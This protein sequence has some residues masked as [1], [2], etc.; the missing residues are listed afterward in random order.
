VGLD[1]AALFNVTAQGGLRRDTKTQS[2][3]VPFHLWVKVEGKISPAASSNNIPTQSIDVPEAQEIQHETVTFHENREPV[4]KEVVQFTEI[5]MRLLKPA[6]ST[7]STDV[8]RILSRPVIVNEFDW[9]TSHTANQI[10]YVTNVPVNWLHSS[11]TEQVALWENKVDGFALLRCKIVLRVQINAMRF[12][13]GRLLVCF[14]PQ[15]DLNT[16]RYEQTNE[17]LTLATQLP[18]V[19]IDCSV[20]STAIL[21]IPYVS[22]TLGY[23]IATGKYGHGYVD[24]RVYSPLVDPSG[25]GKVG[26]TVWAHLEDVELYYPAYT[27]SGRK[28]KRTTARGGSSTGT[29]HE[30]ELKDATGGSVSSFMSGV[31]DVAKKTKEV[32]LLSS[33]AAPVEWAANIGSSIASAFGWSNPSTSAAT[34]QVVVRMAAAGHNIDGID[35]SQKLGLKQDNSVQCLPGAF[36]TNVDEMA[37]E[38]IASHPA[39]VASSTWRSTMVA[40]DTVATYTLSPEL[41]RTGHTIATISITASHYAPFAYLANYF[42]YWRGSLNLTFKFVKTEFHSGRLLFTFNP[43]IAGTVTYTSTD[44]TFREV[45]D[46]RESNEFTVTIPYIANTQYLQFTDSLGVCGFYVLNELVAPSTVNP[47]IEILME[48]NAGKDFEVAVPNE[49][50][51][52]IPCYAR[53]SF[54]TFSAMEA[55]SVE[56]APKLAKHVK[57]EK[58][59]RQLASRRK[60]VFAQCAPHSPTPANSPRRD[61]VQDVMASPLGADWA[62]PSG[63]MKALEINRSLSEYVKVKFQ[64]LGTDISQQERTNPEDP[65]PVDTVAQS[66]LESGGLAAAVYCIGEKILSLRQL[67]KRST[68]YF[69]KTDNLA[70]TREL[71]FKNGM[72]SLPAYTSSGTQEQA[73]FYPDLFNWFGGM[74]AY[75]RGGFRYRF[76]TRDTGFANALCVRYLGDASATNYLPIFQVPDAKAFALGP[77]YVWTPVSGMLEFEVPYYQAVPMVVNVNWLS[78][79]YT[80]D[81]VYDFS[82][83]AIRANTSCVSFNLMRQI[84]DD[85]ELG[86]FI[87]VP[88]MIAASDYVSPPESW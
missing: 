69:P 52:Y 9:T 53:N 35:T 56:P 83:F 24:I 60:I 1:G 15:A 41:M 70:N 66:T 16:Q 59:V 3:L 86:Y 43:S 87:G 17:S 20:N 57:A 44:Y 55:M 75:R 61:L 78:H 50:P 80:A 49:A 36:G 63:D 82:G 26:V 76:Y 79:T 45:V 5:D 34:E 58:D 21:E 42:R 68:I 47:D 29:T 84:S 18:R 81:P 10:I 62:L 33:I 46:I 85:C 25:P 23:Q 27:Q 39:Y 37:I 22:P 48:I 38:H 74:F 73:Y 64:A 30:E 4:T 8:K 51:A 13:Q 40:G 65:L 2:N 7:I 14:F 71:I 77:A 12:Q 11:G 88:P 67:L 32:P 31:A 19:E 6:E 28:T 72:L 54:S